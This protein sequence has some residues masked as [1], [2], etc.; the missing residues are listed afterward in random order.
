[1]PW[2][3]ATP[4]C[5]AGGVSRALVQRL[6]SMAG[7]VRG[8]MSAVLGATLSISSSCS[9]LAHLSKVVRTRR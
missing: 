6:A 1:M 2:R 7:V 9:R 4:I 8:V 3:A 5:R